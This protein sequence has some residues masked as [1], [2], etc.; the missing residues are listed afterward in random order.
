MTKILKSEYQA[1]I[2]A[3][4]RCHN[5]KSAAYANYGGRGIYVCDEWRG[6]DGYTKFIAHIG[7]KADK[8]LTLDRIDNDRGYEPGNV[9]WATR[10]EQQVNRRKCNGVAVYN[11][12]GGLRTISYN[13]ETLR[14]WEWAEKTG[15][16]VTTI[17]KRYREGLSPDQIL[18]IKP[19]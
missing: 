8:A 17:N 13:G 11:R 2:N 14:P 12:K 7:P 1:L 6:I 18:S 5:S 9:R 15:L 3:I 10:A 19:T 4:H 16:S